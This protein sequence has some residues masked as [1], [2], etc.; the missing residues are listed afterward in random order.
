MK[1]RRHR[2]QF[3]RPQS[4][5]QEL[6]DELLQFLQ[7]K[8]YSGHPIEF[9]KD[10]PRLLD[11]VVLWPARWFD[12]RGVTITSDRY[13]S[14]FFQVFTDALRFGNTGNITYLPAWLAKTI[15]SHFSIHGEDY[16]NEAKMVRDQAQTALLSL[17][18]MVKAGPD[19]VRDLAALAALI[20]TSRKPV[21]KA[22]IND[23]LNLL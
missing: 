2:K 20:K 4:T 9:A 11:W 1:P 8:F 12:Q 6:L 18:R 13:R 16:Y 19:P 7:M 10:R 21:K 22:P 15:Q 3:F 5:P 17:G 14:I 23:Q